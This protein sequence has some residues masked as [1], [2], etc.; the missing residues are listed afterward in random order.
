M[1]ISVYVSGSPSWVK[2]AMIVRSGL[3]C[4]GDLALGAE[5]SRSTNVIITGFGNGNGSTRSRDTSQR[6][7]LDGPSAPSACALAAWAPTGSAVNGKRA[8]MCFN[9][10]SGSGMDVGLPTASS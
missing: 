8:R 7:T 5:G 1:T 3:R 6:D 9:E 2:P 10:R 4:E